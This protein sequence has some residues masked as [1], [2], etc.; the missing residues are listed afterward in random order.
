MRRRKA[1]PRQLCFVFEDGSDRASDLDVVAE[2]ELGNSVEATTTVTEIEVGVGVETESKTI[3]ATA[4]SVSVTQT[5]VEVTAG[6]PADVAEAYKAILPQS[7][8]ATDLTDLCVTLLHGLGMTELAKKVSVVW[9]RRFVSAAGMAHYM[10]SK[11]QLNPALVQF[12]GEVDRT[13]RHE[14]AHLVARNRYPNKRIAPHGKEWRQACADLGIPGEGVYHNLPFKT[15]R[16]RRKYAYQ[17]VHCGE[18]LTRVRPLKGHCACYECC[19]KYN[20]GQ[21]HTRFRLERIAVAD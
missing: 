6:M 9:N 11:I 19:K 15:R 2:K 1:D 12:E 5:S 13:L 16:Q 3:G 14:L 18:V 8:P 4:D 10:E 20:R 21:Y 17:C 7:G